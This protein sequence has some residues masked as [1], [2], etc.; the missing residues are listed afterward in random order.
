MLE[1]Y[2]AGDFHRLQ[3]NRKTRWKETINNIDQNIERKKE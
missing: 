2:M 3:L 1:W